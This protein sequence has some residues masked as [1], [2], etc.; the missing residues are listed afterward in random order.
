MAQDFIRQD[1]F[2]MAILLGFFVR[3]FR[4]AAADRTLQGAPRRYPCL[5]FRAPPLIPRQARMMFQHGSIDGATVFNRIFP[6]RP[7]G[8]EHLVELRL[9]RHEFRIIGAVL[10]ADD[11]HPKEKFE[12]CIGHRI[13]NLGK[14]LGS[15]IGRRKRSCGSRRNCGSGESGNGDV[16]QCPPAR[17]GP[18]KERADGGIVMSRRASLCIGNEKQWMVC[19]LLVFSL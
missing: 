13:H 18:L 6:S 10:L 7:P 8:A 15:P 1:D 3:P 14:L 5:Q 17:Y 9:E 2:I 11:D 16:H 19:D 4:K 12:V